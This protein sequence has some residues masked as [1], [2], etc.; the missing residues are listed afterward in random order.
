MKTFALST[1]K[2]SFDCVCG[3]YGLGGRVHVE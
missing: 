3:G 2:V 1:Y